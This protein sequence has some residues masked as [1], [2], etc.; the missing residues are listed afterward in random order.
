MSALHPACQLLAHLKR[1]LHNCVQ[2]EGLVAR[3]PPVLHGKAPHVSLLDQASSISV[4]FKTRNWN[5]TVF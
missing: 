1:M 4:V 3:H 5:F 2:R